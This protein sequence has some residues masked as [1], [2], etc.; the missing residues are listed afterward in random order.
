[1]YTQNDYKI[2]KH[3]LKKDDKTKGLT[4]SNGTTIAEIIESTGLS[5]RKIRVTLN[6]FIDDEMVCYG[7]SIGR[8]RTYCVLKKGLDELKSIRESIIE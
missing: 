5:D 1:M 3:I 4:R 6:R 8:T 7:V 2:L